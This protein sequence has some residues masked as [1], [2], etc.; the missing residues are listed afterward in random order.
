MLDRSA[1]VRPIAHR[2]LHDCPKGVIENTAPAFEAAIENGFADRFGF[3]S[4]VAVRSADELRVLVENLPFAPTEI[5]AAEAA[6]PDVEHLY[7]Y[8]VDGPIERGEVETLS[9]GAAGSDRLS[10]GEKELYLL[11]FGSVRDSKAAARLSRAY[12]SATARNWK[13]VLKL[14]ELAGGSAG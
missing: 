11:C 12:P 1:F 7:V 3:A 2:G 13:T 14:F 6:N 10:A 9:A 4:G 8:F 5:A